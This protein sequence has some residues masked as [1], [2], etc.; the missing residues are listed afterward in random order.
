MRI[1]VDALVCRRDAQGVER[2]WLEVTG[3]G[4]TRLV[5]AT[6]ELIAELGATA[7]PMAWRRP[8]SRGRPAPC[9]CRSLAKRAVTKV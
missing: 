3:K 9:C 7:A 2:W 1:T 5:T 4:K 8:R 6:D